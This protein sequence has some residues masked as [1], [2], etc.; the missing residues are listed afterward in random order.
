I[1]L[2]PDVKQEL[3]RAQRQRA[4]VV[5]ISIIVSI[6]AVAAMALL[7]VYIYGGQTLRNQWADNQI[8][9]LSSELAGIDD[10]SNSLT[11]QNQL[12]KIPELHKDKQMSSRLFVILS[13]IDPPAPN[14]MTI[15]S[16]D[17]S[18]E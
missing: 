1:N 2:I 17:L 16:V 10:L 14:N 4:A 15:A 18:T 8:R 9:D 3:I 6:A 5:S 11:I 12:A 7:A 13:T